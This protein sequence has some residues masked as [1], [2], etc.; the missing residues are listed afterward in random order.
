MI[1]LVKCWI[2]TKKTSYN[3]MYTYN[4]RTLIWI[5]WIRFPDIA[6]AWHSS[7]RNKVEYY[8]GS[9]SSFKLP[10]VKNK[11]KKTYI[12]VMRWIVILMLDWS[13]FKAGLNRWKKFVALLSLLFETKWQMTEPEVSFYTDKSTLR[14]SLSEEFNFTRLMCPREFNG[15]SIKRILIKIWNKKVNLQKFAIDNGNWI[16]RILRTIYGDFW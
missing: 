9:R 15:K 16:L 6:C 4:W 11:K 8:P 3:S 7:I 14:T 13:I 12:S 2:F 1:L 5:V 10:L